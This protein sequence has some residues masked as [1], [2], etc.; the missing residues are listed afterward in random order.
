MANSYKIFICAHKPIENEIPEGKEYVIVAQNESIKSDDH[1]VIYLTD[2]EFT[3]K[4]WHC[5]GEGCAMRYLWKHPEL[6]P[7]YVGIAH[8]RRFFVSLFGRE[9]V[10]PGLVN[11]YGAIIMNPFIHKGKTR[12]DNWSVQCVDHFEQD[13]TILRQIVHEVNPEFG[14]VYEEMLVDNKQ[15]GC[16]MSIM[17]KEHFL[18][19]CE[20]CF[21]ILDEFDKRTGFVDNHAVYLEIIRRHRTQR[22]VGGVEWQS[23]MQGFYLEWLTDT[24]YRYKFNI[25]TCRKSNIG[26]PNSDIIINTYNRK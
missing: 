15:Y 6:L 12:Y 10:I 20:I 4:H 24:Y 23:R 17:K 16:N 8:Y 21:A 22:M 19:M 14:K 11:T 18:E 1:D 9:K 2:D 7:D 25:K 5:Y 3:K 26:L 13:A